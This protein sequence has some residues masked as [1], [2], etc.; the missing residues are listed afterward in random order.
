[1]KKIVYILT[2]F[3][4]LMPCFT[5]SAQS[6]NPVSD[7]E[8]NR[9]AEEL[10]CPVCENVPLDVCPTKACAQWRELIREKIALG[11]SDEQIK[12]FFAEQYGNQVLAAPPR[13]GLNWVIYLLPIIIIAAGALAVIRL[14]R[15]SQRKVK[16]QNAL[17]VDHTGNSE[18][19]F[20]SQVERDL[21]ESE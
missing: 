20:I 1:M 15:S 2:L 7:D 19:E 11:W 21:Q 8:V 13:S 17:Q 12:S 14:L 5:A 18:G 10:Y 6:D 4:M 9:L 3:A 16:T